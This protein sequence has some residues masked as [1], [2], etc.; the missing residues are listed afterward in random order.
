MIG[1][2]SSGV[3]SRRGQVL[4][5]A[6]LSLILMVAAGACDNDDT[7]PGRKPTTQSQDDL[8][9]PGSRL[10]VGQTATVPLGSDKD[11]QI[12]RITITKITEGDPADLAPLAEPPGPRA[13]GKE[14]PYYVHYKLVLVSGETPYLPIFNILSGW[15]GHESLTGVSIL[16]P[17]P[18]CEPRTFQRGDSVG[19]PVVGC[20]TYVTKNG[21]PPLDR[22]QFSEGER[23]G[24][25]DGAPISWE[26]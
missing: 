25:L 15:A 1:S 8:T 4:I 18:P 13:L 9:A 16:V 20:A 6:L 14:T 2:T 7:E 19:V 10:K 12:L 3:L 21:D 24:P 26:P 5:A 17:F 11:D 22:I 23:Y